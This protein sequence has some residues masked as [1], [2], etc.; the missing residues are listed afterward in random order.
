[1]EHVARQDADE[2]DHDLE[3]DQHGGAGLEKHA[4]GAIDARAEGS[5]RRFSHRRRSRLS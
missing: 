1:M 5:G 4:D 3:R 2:Q